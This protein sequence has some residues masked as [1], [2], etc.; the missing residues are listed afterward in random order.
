MARYNRFHFE[1]VL[2][3]SSSLKYEILI[4]S[5]SVN[6]LYCSSVSGY[7]SNVLHQ[8]EAP[9]FFRIQEASFRLTTPKP[10]IDIDNILAI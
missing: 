6:I 5:P 1:V 4:P 7:T 9:R 2:T 8:F 10:D 3:S